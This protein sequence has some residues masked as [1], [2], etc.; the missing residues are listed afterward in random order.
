MR[1]LEAQGVQVS[2]GTKLHDDAREMRSFELGVERR[3]ERVV[4]HLED[5]FLHFR[6]LRLLLQC[7]CVFVFMAYKQE[8]SAS[9]LLNWLLLACRR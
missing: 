7:H 1:V 2:T 9:W 3:E 8:A 5:F 6:S 4:E